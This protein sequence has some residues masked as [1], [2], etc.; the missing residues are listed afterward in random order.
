MP[1]TS[2]SKRNDNRKGSGSTVATFTDKP[3]DGA[4]A[5][6]RMQHEQSKAPAPQ[7]AGE[8]GDTLTAADEQ[9]LDKAW[10]SITDAEMARSV[11][12]TMRDQQK[13]RAKGT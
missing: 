12:Q 5:V 4:A 2:S 10:A 7:P 8:Y 6:E 9:A 1:H 3:W 13:Q 11:E